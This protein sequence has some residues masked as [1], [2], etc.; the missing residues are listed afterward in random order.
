M[1]SIFL[2]ITVCG[3]LLLLS[4]CW[5]RVEVN[6]LAIVTAAAI[7][8]K[9]DNQ[10]ELSIQVF[11]PKT[12]SSGGG[13]EG[14]SSGGE[15]VTEVA[16]SK[17]KNVAEAL[18]KLQS[19][20][21]R[22][23]FWGQCKVFIFGEEVAKDGIQDHLDFLLRHPQTRER[24]YAYVGEGKAKRILETDSGMERYSAEILLEVSDLG[25][26]M[27]TTLKDLNEILIG[28]S[29]AAAL[30]YVKIST[31]VKKKR[32]ESYHFPRIFGTAVFQKDQ[33]VG[34][35]TERETR[36]ILWLRNEVKN[37]TVTV[38]SKEL[39][40]DVSL[41]PV[42]T[43]IELIPRMDGGKWKM[44][45]NIHTEGNVVQNG[46]NIDFTDPKS[47]KKV[48]KVYQEAI[49][50]RIELALQLI[51]HDLKTDIVD[52]AKEFERKYPQQ[53]KQVENRWEEVFPE[54][55]VKVNVKTQI[56]GQ[57]LYSKPGK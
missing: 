17:G 2:L 51:Q 15:L 42:S 46:T 12:F 8:K 32:K 29:H 4:G 49:K 33:M 48:E 41:N 26:A 55:E 36:G 52:F 34:K 24:A 23:I 25:I 38:H 44:N 47:V 13:Q 9:G 53:W 40:G 3:S 14:G 19:Y 5:D 56:R 35:I 30:P 43:D 1:K 10:I 37:Y 6:S 50:K 18:S 54:V 22:K 7:D 16:S 45:V 21:P 20:M 57:G 39:K 31:A 27:R 11:I 28:P